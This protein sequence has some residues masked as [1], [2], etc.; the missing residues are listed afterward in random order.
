MR[1]GSS[2]LSAMRNAVMVDDFAAKG[3]KAW[4][5]F[6]ANKATTAVR[7]KVIFIARRGVVIGG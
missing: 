6:N 2:F 7:R 4:A 5:A 1:V 3:A